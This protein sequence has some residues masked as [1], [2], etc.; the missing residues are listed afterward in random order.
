MADSMEWKY[1]GEA[2]IELKSRNSH[3]LGI[4]T[5]A[6]ATRPGAVDGNN[7]TDN[8]TNTTS[9]SVGSSSGVTNYLVVYGGASPEEGPLGDT[10]YASLPA[11][12]ASIG[13]HR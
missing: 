9:N 12:P 5:V 3:S 8:T 7:T 13:E 11:D 6:A 10:V 2:G 4:V 1:V